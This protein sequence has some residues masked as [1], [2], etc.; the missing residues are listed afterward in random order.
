MHRH[1]LGWT[2]PLWMA[3]ATTAATVHTDEQGDHHVQGQTYSAVV[4]ARGE[5]V[6]LKVSGVEMFRPGPE[7]E[8]AVPFP[9]KE[10]ALSVRRDGPVIAARAG[11]VWV[12]YAFDDTGIKVSS[13][14]A[15][16]QARLADQ[17]VVLV[18]ENGEVRPYDRAFA[19]NIVRVV[20]GDAA[21]AFDQPFHIKHHLLMRSAIPRGRATGADRMDMRIETG[22]S[23][24]TE[25]LIAVRE[26]TATRGVRG[27]APVFAADE[28]AQYRTVLANLGAK[29][30]AV[31]VAWQLLSHYVRG[32]R[33]Q[34]QALPPMTVEPGQDAELTWE[35]PPPGPGIHWLQVEFRHGEAVLKRELRAFVSDP[36]AYA[37]RLTRPAD[38]DEFW[39]AQVEAARAV[40]L[41]PVVSENAARSS[42]HAVHQS[43][44]I[45]VPGRDLVVELQ[46]P[47]HPGR[48]P[49]FFNA[50]LADKA[51]TRDRVL[52][53]VPHGTWPDQARYTAWASARDNNLLQC[54]LIA[55]RITDCL[56]SRPDVD[57]IH[58][59]GASR[60]GPIQLVNAALDPTRIVAVESHVPTSMGVSWPDYPYHGWG[61][62][63]SDITWAAYVDPVNFADRLTV[64]YI[65]DLGLYDGLSPAPGGLA[66]H[67]LARR[68]PFRRL[69]LE[70]GG[71]GYF[72]SGFKKQAKADLAAHLAQ[73]TDAQH[74]ERIL[75]DH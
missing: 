39:R 42:E 53:S 60:Q 56:R 35:V 75:T 46:A 30:T 1:M 29:P 13:Q 41:A 11:D 36:A 74:D 50:K 40:A 21:I 43:V 72:T 12:E 10:P 5:W 27:L 28:Q 45:N 14:G 33:G 48:Y 9:G 71:H 34:W 44:T 31:T 63:P 59:M 22:V 16:W 70:L 57:V 54:Y 37:P 64:P 55:L 6:S 23:A 51:D 52:V 66:F 62:V 2:V 49:A 38:F 58:L 65:I 4:N 24:S 17:G 68:A 73:P 20:K 47:R 67:N 15:P 18:G 69:S 3:A 25:A 19:G 7:G 61:S 26:L 8:A 32:P